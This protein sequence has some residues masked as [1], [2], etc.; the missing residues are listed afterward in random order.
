VDEAQRLEPRDGS[1]ELGGPALDEAPVLNAE[2][3]QDGELLASLVAMQTGLQ[4]PGHGRQEVGCGHAVEA[5]HDIGA[6]RVVL[7]YVVDACSRS[8]PAVSVSRAYLS[9]M[10]GVMR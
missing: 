10:V 3:L 5:L 8:R 1:A 6:W 9:T 4:A 2:H 7:E